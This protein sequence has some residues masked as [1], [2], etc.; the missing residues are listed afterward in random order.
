[1]FLD[2]LIRCIFFV[3]VLRFFAYGLDLDLNSVQNR[4]LIQPCRNF[5]SF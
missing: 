2:I 4:P 1:M 5:S 3:C